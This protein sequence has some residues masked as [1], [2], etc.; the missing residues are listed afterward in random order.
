MTSE[1]RLAANRRNALAST[2]PKSRAG[3]ARA[4]GNARRHGLAIPVRSDPV[5]AADVEAL[6]KAI[7]GEGADVELMGLAREIA[8]AQ[9][10]IV[11]VRRARLKAVKSALS[12]PAIP[13][14]G[15]LLS[16]EHCKQLERLD[17][18]ERR[19]LSRRKF[20]IRSFGTPHIGTWATGGL[21]VKT[22]K[23]SDR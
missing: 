20:A 16:A 15:G 1:R 13:Q 23:P 22:G 17:R 7:A 19:A 11:R 8:E 18:Y 3:K 14:A 6:A 4:A 10:E 9:I 12:G 2:G 5:L 21:A